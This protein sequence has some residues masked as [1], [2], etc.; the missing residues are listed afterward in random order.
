MYTKIIFEILVMMSE[1]CKRKRKGGGEDLCVRKE[2]GELETRKGDVLI[3]RT[4]LG[5]AERE[6][7]E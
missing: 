4:G 2:G 6:R 5:P 7:E 1:A 3:D